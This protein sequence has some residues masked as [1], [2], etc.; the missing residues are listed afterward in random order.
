MD[1]LSDFIR[2]TAAAAREGKLSPEGAERL[3]AWARLPKGGAG[4]IGHGR[5]RAAGRADLRDQGRRDPGART[6]IPKS[7]GVQG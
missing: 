6:T 4:P 1:E 3:S 2:V 7:F 5:A